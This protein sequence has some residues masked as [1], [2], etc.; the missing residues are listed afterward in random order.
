MAVVLRYDLFVMRIRGLCS[1]FLF[2]L[3]G[4]VNFALQSGSPPQLLPDAD[5]FRLILHEGS[6]QELAVGKS[7]G[8]EAGATL[9][10]R[11]LT[12]TLENLSKRTI[13]LTY[14]ECQGPRLQ[15]EIPWPEAGAD[16]WGTVSQ[17]RGIRC[18]ETMPVDIRLSPG[19]KTVYSTRMISDLLQSG[20]V[21]VGK[22]VLRA[23]WVLWGCSEDV[24]GDNC[25]HVSKADK[26][27]RDI[28]WQ[29]PVEVVSN[30]ITADSPDIAGLGEMKFVLNLTETGA[31]S[32]AAVP[33][34]GTCDE[35][36]ADS[37]SCKV[38]HWRL[39]NLTG[40]TLLLRRFSCS[41][42]TLQP[43]QPQVLDKEG[44]WAAVEL[45]G[46]NINCN[47]SDWF[48]SVLPAGG[49]LEGDF[50]LGR[51]RGPGN[52]NAVHAAGD[53]R[54]RLFFY[55]TACFASPDG[56]FC[57]SPSVR[58]LPAVGSDELRVHASA[59]GPQR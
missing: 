5:Q 37:M 8:G 53:Y 19:E 38:F 26:F 21:L 7:C 29:I 31:L 12:L 35:A 52:R 34:E 45:A 17:P 15:F 48:S 57:I 55:P 11:P 4:Q 54:L 40:R 14:P 20:G 3:F 24:A 58:D 18:T 9:T 46:E 30:E 22:Q 36:T 6:D 13:H 59:D 25:L 10:C 47:S 50:R 27:P 39:R 28:D 49:S 44:N 1:L 33:S 56:V 23:R 2:L 43:L 42:R 51:P 32:K 41:G 16:K